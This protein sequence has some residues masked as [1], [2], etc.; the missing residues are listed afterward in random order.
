MNVI[1]FV[2]PKMRYAQELASV[3]SYRF[4]HHVATHY[5]AFDG[6]HPTWAQMR[7]FW[8]MSDMW[9]RS[10]LSNH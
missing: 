8:Q 6:K 7:D 5:G 4:N 2:F 1:Q 3:R 10:Y 9:A